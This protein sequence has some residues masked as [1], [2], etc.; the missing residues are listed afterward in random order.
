MK[1]LRVL[2]LFLLAASSIS[3]TASP[4]SS[5]DSVVRK[6]YQEVVARK[7]LG[8]PKGADRTAIWPYLSKALIQKLEVAQN[9]EDDY[10][11][12]H[13][14][15]GQKPEFGWLEFGLFSG[16][17]ERG[18]PAAAVV[19]RTEPQNDGSF[20]VYVRLTYKESP[21]TYGR[22][23]TDANTSNWD[24]AAVVILESGRLVVDNVLLMNGDSTKVESRLTNSFSGCSGPH[25][26]GDKDN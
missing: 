26:V 8:I 2:V 23:P 5:P 16:A 18:I 12:H 19:T 3:L 7:P 1:K 10:F 22:T 17:N 15:E 25:W 4:T 11:R 9:C 21:E 13:A 20:L 6:L 24:V 14:G